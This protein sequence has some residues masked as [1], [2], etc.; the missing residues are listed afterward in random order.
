MKIPGSLVRTTWKAD[1][2]L[3]FVIALLAL[4]ALTRE[5][6]FATVGAVILLILAVLG[7]IFQRKLGIFQLR[8]VLNHTLS[9]SQALIGAVVDGKLIIRNGSGITAYLVGVEGVA[10]KA[11]RFK[12]R[13]TP[14]EL[15]VPGASAA[16]FFQIV[17][18]ATGRF[19]FSGYTLTL[20]DMSGL[21]TGQLTFELARWID[22]YIG[23]EAAAKPLT[24]LILYGGRAGLYSIGPAGDD[25]AGIRDYSTGDEQHRIE[26]KAT[27]RLGK[28][29]VKEF[30]P[31]TQA[32]VMILLDTSRS[33][34]EKSYV[35]TK[36]DEALAVAQL[37]G[38]SVARSGSKSIILLHNEGGLVETIS[39]RDSIEQLDRLNEFA[40]T[41]QTED[42]PGEPIPLK[43]PRS[44]LFGNAA[45]F[46]EH[47]RLAFFMRSLI[48]GLRLSYKKTGVYKALDEATRLNPEGL[49]L[50]LTDLQTTVD[51]LSEFAS[52]KGDKRVRI[53][54]AQIG[55]LWRRSDTLESA[56]IEY[57]RNR[58]ILQ[59]LQRIGITV[60][61]VRPER[62]IAALTNEISQRTIPA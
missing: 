53:V 59:R 47:E 12:L 8:F 36:L 39:T 28:L 29:M 10:S 2:L 52:T 19:R 62:L 6:I 57:Q 7:A 25:Y 13:T 55:A 60:L 43:P 44:F 34:R 16:L 1:W 35:G 9:R 58:R 51:A 45:P 49:I 33:M 42:T 17:P 48:R 3:E 24:A 41:F 22:T 14:D 4:S 38:N 11:L 54:V 40:V 61:D 5:I 23:T 46:L 56:Y 32:T 31:E 15:L 30:H 20:T 26:W 50:V 18:L 27:A 21:F 37:L